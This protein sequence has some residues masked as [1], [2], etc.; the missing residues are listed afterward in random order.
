M[1]APIIVYHTYPKSHFLFYPFYITIYPIIFHNA[2]QLF[3]FIFP[4]YSCYIY[5]KYSGNFSPLPMLFYYIILN[6]QINPSHTPYL[7]S[8]WQ[9]TSLH[10]LYLLYKLPQ[11]TYHSYLRLLRKLCLPE[12]VYLCTLAVNTL[13]SRI[14]CLPCCQII[15]EMRLPNLISLENIPCIHFLLHI[16][17][18][19]IITIRNNC[20]ALC[21]KFF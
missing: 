11:T 15:L 8:V 19:T 7:L 21:F 3:L 9:M 17:K 14:L 4:F 16:I 5:K 20:L 18:T 1:L 13:L 12:E 6:L 2:N 10:S